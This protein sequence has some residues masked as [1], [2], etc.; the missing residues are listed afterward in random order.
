MNDNIPEM[1]ELAP[2]KIRV[3]KSDLNSYFLAPCSGELFPDFVHIDKE[4]III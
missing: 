4:I 1:K 2:L 3:E